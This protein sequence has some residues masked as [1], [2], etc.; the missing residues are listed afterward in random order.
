IA[1]DNKQFGAYVLLANLTG[2]QKYV[3]DANRWLQGC[4]P[5]RRATA[6]TG[7]GNGVRTR[8]TAGGLTMRWYP[9]PTGAIDHFWC[10]APLSAHCTASPPPTRR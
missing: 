3:D 6:R 5:V 4:R 1:W 7:A 10:R 9:S 8:T 2:K